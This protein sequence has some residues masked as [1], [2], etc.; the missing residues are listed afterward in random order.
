MNRTTA[1]GYS[2]ETGGRVIVLFLLF[3]L[4]L[5][6]FYS[7]GLSG[8]AMVC[9]VPVSILYA[10][11]AFRYRM[12]T[13]WLMFI[14]NFLLHFIYRT[15]YLSLPMSL[16]NEMFELLLIAIAIIDTKDNHFERVGNPML[17]AIGV[18]CIFCTLEVFND[19]CDLGLDVPGW[20]SG[21][22]LMAYQM[23]YI[24]LVFILYIS[25]PE[26]LLKYLRLWAALCI[27][28]V[29]WAWKQKNIGFT[30]GEKVFL[31]AGG[32]RT[33]F[34]GGIMRYFS[35][36]SDAANYG[37]NM[38]VT[39]VAFYIFSITSKIKF[40]KVLFLVT[41]LFTTWG[42]FAS[43]TRT[44]IFCMI[45]GFGIYIF[46]SKSFKIA[47]PVIIFFGLFI[48]MLAFTKIGNGNDQIR[49]MRTAFD[50]NDQSKGARDTNQE[51]MRKYMKDAPWGIGIR[52]FDNVPK[53]NKYYIMAKVP[54]DSEY[55][56]IWLRTGVIG[57]TTFLICLVIMLCG[58]CWIVFFKLKNR[59]VQGIGA[60]MCCMFAGMQV[61][62]YGNQVLMQFPN[63][64]ILFGGL[65]I[66]Y[67][68]PFIEPAFE[69][70]EAKRYAIQEE[71]KRL[72]LEKKRASRV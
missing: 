47:I 19:T 22:R 54:P 35:L 29:F 23:I 30:E 41:A 52:S 10:Y 55:V 67:A 18:W 56:Y 59:A 25:T 13:F 63:G 36:F 48:S 1:K 16:P 34:V 5:Y 72:K 39:S 44:A 14:I 58:A 61:G 32:M 9:M 7:M 2:G 50:P 60:G 65:A 4:A 70:M 38:A 62:A 68:L 8:I 42:M 37:C 45:I 20:F 12:F 17:F 49:R 6:Q 57:L 15:V 27:F 40:D 11:F 66:V 26:R 24:Y 51:A 71:K 33:H 43:G 3:F 64:M 28:A 53:N 31:E 69:E 46:L 21:V